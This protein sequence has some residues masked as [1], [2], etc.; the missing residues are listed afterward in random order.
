MNLKDLK[1]YKCYAV[2]LNGVFSSSWMDKKAAIKFCYDKQREMVCEIEITPTA[3]I[4]P[5]EE[6]NMNIGNFCSIHKNDMTWVKSAFSE[7]RWVCYEC[8]REK[9]MQFSKGLYAGFSH[10]QK[11]A[12][13]NLK[14]ENEEMHKQILK[15]MKEKEEP[16]TFDWLTAMKLFADGVEIQLKESRN[17]IPGYAWVDVEMHEIGLISFGKDEEYRR[18]P[19]PKEK[20]R[21]WAVLYNEAVNMVYSSKRMAEEACINS[22]NVIELQEVEPEGEAIA[23]NTR[24][25]L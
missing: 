4:W 2:Y 1:P 9:S 19:Q 15:S 24:K 11:D 14:K 8:E 7:D 16:A 3:M 22:G 17:C 25:D 5:K 20:K 12:L 21:Y 10:E 23:D 18:K 13:S 6:E